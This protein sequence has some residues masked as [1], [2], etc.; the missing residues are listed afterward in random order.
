[1]LRAP[2]KTS[3]FRAESARP[4]FGSCGPMWI[5][6]GGNLGGDFVDRLVV[7]CELGWVE[8][9]I[10]LE[11]LITVSH[12]P[13][14]S[15]IIDKVHCLGAVKWIIPKGGYFAIQLSPRNYRF[16]HERHQGSSTFVCCWSCCC[17]GCWALGYICFWVCVRFVYDEK[18]VNCACIDNIIGLVLGFQGRLRQHF[19][20][21]ILQYTNFRDETTHNKTSR[22]VMSIYDEASDVWDST[23]LLILLFDFGE[24][25]FVS[26]AYFIWWK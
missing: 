13:A 1:M 26:M 16:V 14:E 21:K 7:V 22:V 20:T 11:F 25:T 10:F 8:F 24:S 2:S 6:V 17:C 18:C 3:K 15:W 12:A 5:H 9:Y 4:T 23:H 19:T